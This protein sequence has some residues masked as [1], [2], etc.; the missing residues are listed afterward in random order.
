MRRRTFIIAACLSAVVIA[1]Y[2]LA[3]ID[4]VY[5]Q[6]VDSYGW[7]VCNTATGSN[8]STFTPLSDSAAAAKVTLMTENRPT[9]ASATGVVP[10]PNDYIPSAAE[11]S[12]FRTGETN[13]NGQTAV[14]FNPYEAYVTGGYSG[15]TDDII[16]WGAAKWGIPADWLRAE[17]VK[18]SY[19]HQAPPNGLACSAQSSVCSGQGCGDF[20]AVS[21]QANYPA[22]SRVTSGST[23]GACQSLG[24]AQPKWNHPDVNNAQVG[25]EPL[26]WKSTAFNVDVQASYLRFYFDDP[27]GT[28]SAW[29]DASYVRCQNWNSV[30]AWYSPYPWGNS[31]QLSYVSAIQN[32]LNNTQDWKQAAFPPATPLNP[33]TGLRAKSTAPR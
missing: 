33:P 9:N 26:R 16:Q 27:Q 25:I 30:G 3:E 8:P 15:T 1:G 10:D 19:W 5:G 28:R 6:A 21:N 7:T 29:G 4:P 23:P 11:I 13:I 12:A 22:Y 20:Y 18:E 2:L 14:Q 31:D 24:I 32:I 17:Y